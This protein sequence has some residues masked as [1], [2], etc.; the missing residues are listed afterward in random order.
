[1]EAKDWLKS[2]EKKLE[3]AQC[4]DWEKVL[5]AAHRLLMLSP[6]MNSKLDLELTMYRMV[7]SS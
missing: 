4:T 3:I 2:I 1:M 6:G 5:F 7:H